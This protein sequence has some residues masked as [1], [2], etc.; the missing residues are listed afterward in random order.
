MER[1]LS[2]AVAGEER[3]V[4][5]VG[6]I[7]WNWLERSRLVENGALRK[8]NIEIWYEPVKVVYLL[9]LSVMFG[10][11]YGSLEEMFNDMLK[12]DYH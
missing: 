10:G 5:M 9:M 7:V 1:V 4:R 2:I 6:R 8:R 11:E 3:S 12:Y